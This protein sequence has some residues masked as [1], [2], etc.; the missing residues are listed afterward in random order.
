MKTRALTSAFLLLFL[1]G[2]CDWNRIHG[3]G[4]IKT[5]HRPVAAF[6]QVDAGGF[7][8]MEWHPGPPS[9]SLTTDE[10]LLSQITTS[11]SGDELKIAMK[12]GAVAPSDG[13]RIVITSPSLK[14]VKL[15]GAVE[16]K[17][18]QLAGSKFALETSGAA[19]VVLS[20]KVDRLLADL[21]GAS[22][23][24]AAD[25]SANDVELSVTGAG[26]AD[27]TAANSLQASITGAGKVSYGGNP[28]SVKKEIAGAGSIKPRE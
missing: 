19:K 9:F 25:L 11:V 1:F 23:L 6:T 3:N 15:S 28:K 27:V 21:T 10:N 4:Q 24:D 17:A 5:D 7:Y 2:G 20:G 13:I 8:Q 22:K 12:E 26:K 16:F 18:S 14:G